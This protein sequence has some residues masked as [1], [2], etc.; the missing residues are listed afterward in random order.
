MLLCS[1]LLLMCLCG[2]FCLC[3]LAYCALLCGACLVVWLVGLVG[4][5][6]LRLGLFGVCCVAVWLV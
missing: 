6:V 4:C 2:D 5:A 3:V 1:W